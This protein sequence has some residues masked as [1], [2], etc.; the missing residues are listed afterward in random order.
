V[1]V[2][3]DEGGA[4]TAAAGDLRQRS[5]PR[6][7][8]EPAVDLKPCITIF[9]KKKAPDVVRRVD[10][11]AAAAYAVGGAPLDGGGDMPV[12]LTFA[13][14]DASSKAGAP[15]GAAASE[16]PRRS[17]APVA[18]PRDAVEDDAEDAEDPLDRTLR[19]GRDATGNRS[20]L[21]GVSKLLAAAVKGHSSH[22][23]PARH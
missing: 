22:G 1:P 3:V 18:K 14:A 12:S 23:G 17:A 9:E 19:F 21:E 13:A 7:A 8:S 10:S 16:M 2:A 4:G 15:P 11:S 5:R 20:M 6:S